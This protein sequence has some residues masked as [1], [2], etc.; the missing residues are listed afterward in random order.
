MTTSLLFI[1][2]ILISSIYSQTRTEYYE[3]W[4]SKLSSSS[5]SFSKSDVTLTDIVLPGSRHA[6]MYTQAIIDNN[7]AESADAYFTDVLDSYD[8]DARR[9]K[10]SSRQIGSVYDQLSAGSRV[11]DIRLEKSSGIYAHNGLLGASLNTV[12]SFVIFLYSIYLFVF[13]FF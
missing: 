3:S 5:S 6:G 8:G 10:W 1:F 13:S 9:L 12:G 4:I 7:Y 11:L 2:S